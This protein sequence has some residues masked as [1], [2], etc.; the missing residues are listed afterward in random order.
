[1]RQIVEIVVLHGN[2]EE[3]MSAFWKAKV[4]EIIEVM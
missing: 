4:L 2:N 1:M 3:P